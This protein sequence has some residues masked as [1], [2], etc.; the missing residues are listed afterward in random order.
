MDHGRVDF[1]DLSAVAERIHAQQSCRRHAGIE[2]LSDASPRVAQQA[3]V[4][5]NIDPK[6]ADVSRCESVDVEED[7]EVRQALLGLA[8]RIPRRDHTSVAIVRNLTRHEQFATD[9]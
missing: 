5:H 4:S 2:P 7:H 1:N 9:L 3:L 6:A 8:F